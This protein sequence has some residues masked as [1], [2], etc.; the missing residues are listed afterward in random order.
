MSFAA[1]M[2]PCAFTRMLSSRLANWLVLGV[3]VGS[4]DGEDRLRGQLPGDE[5]LALVLRPAAG[6]RALYGGVLHV[7]GCEAFRD[8]GVVDRGDEVGGGLGECLGRPPA[9]GEDGVEG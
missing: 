5:P 6:V 7:V 2:A 1:L 8:Q 3:Q 9:R 4:I